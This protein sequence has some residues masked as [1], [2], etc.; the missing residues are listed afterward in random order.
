MGTDQLTN[1]MVGGEFLGVQERPEQVTH[2]ASNVG[3]FGEM[4]LGG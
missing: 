4:I 2:P 3:S 1:S